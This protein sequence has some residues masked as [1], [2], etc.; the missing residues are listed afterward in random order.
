MQLAE[1]LR[2]RDKHRQV[3]K[4]QSERMGEIFY[5]DKYRPTTR[6]SNINEIDFAGFRERGVN[7]LLLD[8]E[9]TI[10]HQ[11]GWDID[12]GIIDNIKS[13]GFDNIA[14]VTNKRPKNEKEFVRLNHWAQQLGENAVVF[15]PTS[16]SE[17]KPSSKMLLKA[18]V[19]FGIKPDEALVV[20]DKLT[21]DILAANR[22]GMW[23]AKVDRLGREDLPGDRVV[24]RPIERGI[25]VRVGRDAKNNPF[26]K[27][28]ESKA[29]L[30][31]STLSVDV[32]RV[33]SERPEWFDN[34]PDDF[35]DK[36]RIVGYGLPDVL[37]PSQV[38]G[39][40]SL[41]R[42]EAHGINEMNQ[43]LQTVD[44]SV[45]EKLDSMLEDYLYEH[46]REVAD[47]VTKIRRDGSFVV[48]GL[49]L[50]G[51]R[52]TAAVVYAG[53]IATDG[54]DGYAARR[55]KDG[56]TA[57]GA[58]DDQEADKKASRRVELAEVITGRLDP[59]HF[60]LREASNE[61][62]NRVS[63][64][65]YKNSGHDVK[66]TMSGKLATVFVNV[67]EIISMVTKD[68]LWGD[69]IQEIATGMK[70]GRIPLSQRTWELNKRDNDRFK[71]VREHMLQVA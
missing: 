53:L 35:W 3:E 50:L 38:I 8:A 61:Y 32:G 28:P 10:V 60:L 15:A 26:I 58:A 31:L 47:L 44:A 27:P 40:V 9:G 46:G 5:L 45:A 43:T 66:A 42:S 36:S 57:D 48:A 67:A 63:R 11:N 14:I 51:M 20:G 6:V 59:I 33:A 54:I 30:A 34:A 68:T 19:H 29:G 13:Q 18:A 23:S 52:K 70:L 21:S 41:G 49:L 64:P 56:A 25:E 4:I 65:I 7:T 22:T 37:L 62:M 24:R 17:R 16:R 1:R 55:H 2:G 71:E 12:Q 39:L 69:L